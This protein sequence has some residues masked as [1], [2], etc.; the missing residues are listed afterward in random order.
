MAIIPFL[1]STSCAEDI[2]NL[3]SVSGLSSSPMRNLRKLEGRFV[4]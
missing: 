3:I 1:S 4:I 2:A